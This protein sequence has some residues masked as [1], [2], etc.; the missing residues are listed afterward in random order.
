MPGLEQVVAA[1][2]A[3]FSDGPPPALDDTSGGDELAA[4]A[5]A[6]A[7]ETWRTAPP[8]VLDAVHDALPWLDARSFAYWLPGLLVDLVSDPSRSGWA[9]ESLILALTPAAASDLP[10]ALGALARAHARGGL[11]DAAHAS[12]ARTVTDYHAGPRSRVLA[13][14]W[15]QLTPAQRSAV[16]GALDALASVHANRGA[17]RAVARWREAGTS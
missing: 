9:G 2:S 1:L 16:L 13:E 10:E 3:A 12:A 15:R 7:G 8:A 6:I 11:D 14:R 5:T 17:I 4:L